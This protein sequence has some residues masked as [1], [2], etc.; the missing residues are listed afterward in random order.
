MVPSRGLD[1]P[2]LFV[3]NCYA[4]SSKWNKLRFTRIR[5]VMLKE[6]PMFADFNL[7][8]PDEGAHSTPWVSAIAK[9]HVS[10]EK[11][12]LKRMSVS[13]DADLTLPEC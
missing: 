8:L 3:N 7:I 9:A 12:H 10:S 13:T 11:V 5:S 6:K 1:R 4:V 2:D